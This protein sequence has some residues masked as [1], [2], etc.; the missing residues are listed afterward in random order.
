MGFEWVTVDAREQGAQNVSQG[1]LGGGVSVDGQA[2]EFG[3]SRFRVGD[4]PNGSR[5]MLLEIDQD[6]KTPWVL[7][8]GDFKGVGVY[9]L[10]PPPHGDARTAW[11]EG[12]VVWTPR[13]GGTFIVQAWTP[14]DL[15]FRLDV[16]FVNPSNGH[17]RVVKA[18]GWF[19]PG[20]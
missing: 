15:R 19:K 8:V 3:A 9:G 20:K 7:A 14:T 5:T 12:G 13:L 11:N 6:S 4:E 17:T 1:L 18:D 2:R 10:N 16:T